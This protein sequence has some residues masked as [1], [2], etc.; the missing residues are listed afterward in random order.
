MRELRGDVNWIQ[1]PEIL[2]IETSLLIIISSNYLDVSVAV[3]EL[4]KRDYDILEE[5]L[6]ACNNSHSRI[7]A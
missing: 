3:F 2:E 4:Y 1:Y 7:K 5:P 6:G